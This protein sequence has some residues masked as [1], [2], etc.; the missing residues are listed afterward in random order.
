[1][2]G[3]NYLHP[4]RF[5]VP[6]RHDSLE[7]ARRVNAVLNAIRPGVNR[8]MSLAWLTHLLDGSGHV[9]SALWWN[10]LLDGVPNPVSR[11]EVLKCIARQAG[12]DPDYFTHRNPSRDGNIEA[13]L[14]IIATLHEAQSPLSPVSTGEDDAAAALRKLHVLLRTLKQEP[15]RPLGLELL[16]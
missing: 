14:E 1:M 8:E 11:P 13:E 15:V 9:V 10:N 6:F 2:E 5:N 3:S 16:S 12:I 7:L 4:E